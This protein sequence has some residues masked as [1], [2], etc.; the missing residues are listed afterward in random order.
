MQTCC[1]FPKSLGG[2][3]KESWRWSWPAHQNGMIHTI[4]DR[5]GRHKLNKTE[6]EKYWCPSSYWCVSNCI[7]LLELSPYVSNHQNSTAKL[8]LTAWYLVHLTPCFSVYPQPPFVCQI[9]RILSFKPTVS[10]QRMKFVYHSAWQNKTSWYCFYIEQLHTHTLR[11]V[12]KRFE[13]LWR[14]RKHLMSKRIDCFLPVFVCYY[15]FGLFYEWVCS[16][17]PNYLMVLMRGY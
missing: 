1:C 17:S 14:Y 4:K 10:W 5:G 2:A 13:S 3:A 9:H 8:P 11:G 16:I 12:F 6:S 15:V 7:K